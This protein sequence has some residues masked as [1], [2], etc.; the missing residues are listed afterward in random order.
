MSQEIPVD[1]GK[2]TFVVPEGDWRVHILRGGE[3]WVVISEGHKAIQALL[4][5]L[6]AAQ[7]LAAANADSVRSALWRLDAANARIAELEA[8]WLGKK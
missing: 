3:P 6:D 4:G 5:E 1:G 2:Y 7:M 8:Q